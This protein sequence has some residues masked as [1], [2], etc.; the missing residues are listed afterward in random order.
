MIATSWGV[1]YG[2]NLRCVLPS[3]ETDTTSVTVWSDNRGFLKTPGPDWLQ[4][5]DASVKRSPSWRCGSR[6]IFIYQGGCVIHED[7]LSRRRLDWRSASYRNPSSPSSTVNCAISGFDTGRRGIRYAV[8]RLRRRPY[9][10][11]EM[12]LSVHRLI[13]LRPARA[14]KRDSCLIGFRDDRPPAA[15]RR[16][17]RPP[18]SSDVYRASTRRSLRA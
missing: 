7:W 18:P 4:A 8:R 10:T 3:V 1:L 5:R 9:S 11:S 15:S 12:A 14:D 13:C 6:G 2:E 17:R 16:T